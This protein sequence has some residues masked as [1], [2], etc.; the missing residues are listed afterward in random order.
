MV[1]QDRYRITGTLGKGG[2]GAVYAA[3]DLRFGSVVALKETLVDGDDL[4][5]AFEREAKL[6]NKLRHAALPVVFD[7]FA[8]SEGQFLVMQHIPGDDFAALLSKNGGPFQ[9]EVVIHWADQLLD[10]LEYLHTQQPPIIH[11]DIKPHN[12][13]LTPRGE[14]ILLD[15][16]L[17]KTSAVGLTKATTSVSVL[18]YTPQYAPFEQINGSGTDARSD[19]Y[20]LAAT[21]YHLLTG[22]PPTDAL[23]RAQSVMNGQA[24]PLPT[25]NELNPSVTVQIA[26]ALGAA[27]AMN[28]DQRPAN[29]ATLRAML[30]EGTGSSSPFASTVVEGATVPTDAWHGQTQPTGAQTISPIPGPQ[31]MSLL[32]KAGIV[33]AVLLMIAVSGLV[34]RSIREAAPTSTTVLPTVEISA[35]PIAKIP[36]P[37]EATFRFDTSKLNVGGKVIG[38]EVKQ[39]RYFTEDL[40]GGASIDMVAIPAGKFIMGAPETEQKAYPDEGPQHEV[41]LKRFYMSKFEVTQADWRAVAAQPKVTRDLAP[42]PS[43]FKGDNLPV[44]NISWEEAVEFCARLSKKSARVYH[45]PSESEWEYAARAGSTTAFAFGKT[46]TAELANYD[47][48]ANYG[49]API[50]VSRERTVAVGSL[51]VANDF[52]LY[53]VHGNV[54]E[55]CAGEYHA[56]YQGAPA[57]GSPWLTAGDI[58]HRVTRG[59]GWDSFAVDCR[60]ANRLSYSQDGRRAN[61]GFRL[62]MSLQ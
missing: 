40:G 4:R 28:R 49:L 45:L 2:M 37:A 35:E 20:S 34:W 24:D 61:I 33:F 16:G 7:Y 8:D 5:K 19:L 22:V 52:G 12:L 11:R 23:T 1:L 14:V 31:G 62:A 55:W 47:G 54:R 10:A 32:L 44:E 60:S 53:D 9:P 25:A 15:F 43:K 26:S 57:D 3:T 59:G 6:L 39:G 36:A 13:K 29:A 17:S 21:L 56:N 42:D 46:V 48:T 50:G 58:K 38:R 41:T 51:G 27:M 18:G 30:R